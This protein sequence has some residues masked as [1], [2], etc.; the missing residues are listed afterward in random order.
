MRAPWWI[1]GLIVV[2]AAGCA[3]RSAGRHATRRPLGLEQTERGALAADASR[4]GP[5]A[6]VDRVLGLPRPSGNFH[7]LGPA[8]CQCLAARASNLGN[9]LDGER[10]ALAAHEAASGCSH[11][12]NSSTHDLLRTA[13]LEARNRSAGD[14]LDD[15]YTLAQSEARLD[16]VARALAETQQAM[17]GVERIKRQGLKFPADDTEFARR[18]ITLRDQQA[19]LQNAVSRLNGQLWQ[20]LGITPETPHERIWPTTDLTATVEP[21]DIEAAV[22]FGLA[23]RPELGLLRRLRGSLDADSLP[24]ARAALSQANPLLGLQPP[25]PTCDGVLGL[26]GAIKKIRAAQCELPQRQRQLAQY[27]R[28]RE[29]EIAVEIR[30]AAETVELRLRQIALANEAHNQWQTRAHEVTGRAN[31]GGATFGDVAAARLS[32]IQAEGDLLDAIVAWK[33]AQARLKQSQGLLV[34][35]CCP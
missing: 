33:I 19:Q 10:R 13:A 7:A 29:Q 12:D 32:L 22:Q 5:L 27:T 34:L 20:M 35:E 18:D 23:T 4:V 6:D 9:L 31:T 28:D 11:V 16:F 3:Q 2:L 25:S 24:S 15:Y 8:E 30:Q 17:A 21:T 14:A 1:V 26:C